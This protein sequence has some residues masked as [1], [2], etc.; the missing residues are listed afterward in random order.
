MPFFVNAGF[1]W[2]IAVKDIPQKEPSGSACK[3]IPTEFPGVVIKEQNRIYDHPR[4]YAFG[5]EGGEP[6]YF[7]HR[8]L[9][10]II[11]DKKRMKLG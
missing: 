2:D 9:L 6:E 3:L 5:G 8:Y 7:M 10:G 1:F 11:R 4:G